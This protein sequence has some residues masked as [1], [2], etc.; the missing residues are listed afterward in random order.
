[1]T[2]ATAGDGG[3]WAAAVFYANNDFELYFLSASTTR[4]IQ[5][6][7]VNPR[8]AAAIHED[9]KDW[10]DIKG[11]QLEGEIRQLEGIEREAAVDLYQVKY[12]F[13]ATAGAQLRSALKRVKWY[14]LTPSRLYLIDNSLGLGHRDE[15]TL[16]RAGET[17]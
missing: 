3:P 17:G 16:Q 7:E 12:P 10:P 11:I 14:C 4:H 9:Y 5:S 13:I 1:M 2:L 15:V 8:A 6:L